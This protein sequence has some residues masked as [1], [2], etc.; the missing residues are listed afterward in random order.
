M[1]LGIDAPKDVPVHREEVY[2]AIQ[3]ERRRPTPVITDVDQSSSEDDPAVADPD[4]P[5]EKGCSGIVDRL[6]KMIG[7][8][9]T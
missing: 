4:R 8:E 9:G 5:Q 6:K 1:R 2:K 3:R 7:S